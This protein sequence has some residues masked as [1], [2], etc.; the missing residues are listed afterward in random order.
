MDPK[1]YGVMSPSQ[2]NKVLPNGMS[3]SQMDKALA[4]SGMSGKLMGMLAANPPTF[5][6][7]KEVKSMIDKQF[8]RV[9]GETVRD[10]AEVTIDHARVVFQMGGDSHAPTIKGINVCFAYDDMPFEITL[11][12][13]SADTKSAFRNVSLNDDVGAICTL[14]DLYKYHSGSFDATAA[15][16]ARW[17]D[18]AAAA[19]AAP[20]AWVYSRD[21]THRT[22]VMQAL[23]LSSDNG[24]LKMKSTDMNSLA[25]V[26]DASH[27]DVKQL[28]D[29]KKW[30]EMFAIQK[31]AR[32][33]FPKMWVSKIGFF[34]TGGKH[35][36]RRVSR[37]KYMNKH[38]S[39]SRKH[40]NRK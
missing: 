2:M 40:R 32:E 18:A 25:R 29:E 19:A 1:L 34:P 31:K 23:K 11:D 17:R 21:E 14:Y 13:Q 36:R 12:S 7:A 22:G 39:A 15:N 20:N 24:T 4:M 37:K 27:L 35:N 10:I 38:R 6:E 8:R 26:I 16:P 9:K 28:Y 5:Q 33:L 3:Q 30:D